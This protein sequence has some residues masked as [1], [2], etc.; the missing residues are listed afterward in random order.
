MHPPAHSMNSSWVPAMRLA[1]WQSRGHG[2]KGMQRWGLTTGGCLGLGDRGSGGSQHR[3]W[4]RETTGSTVCSCVIVSSQRTPAHQSSPSL[5][6]RVEPVSP[7]RVGDYSFCFYCLSELFF[8]FFKGSNSMSQWAWTHSACCKNANECI[9]FLFGKEI[10]HIPA[11]SGFG[12]GSHHCHGQPALDWPA[13]QGPNHSVPAA[14]Q[15]HFLTGWGGKGG[16]LDQ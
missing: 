15:F 1:W 9:V 7:T 5:I 2:G 11:F 8:F 6:C 13:S 12:P 3:S 14:D 10:H 16:G 4:T